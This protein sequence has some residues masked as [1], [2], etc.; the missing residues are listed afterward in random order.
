MNT[1]YADVKYFDRDKDYYHCAIWKTY[2]KNKFRKQGMILYS[3]LPIW[4]N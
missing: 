3:V 2:N 4:P 1:S